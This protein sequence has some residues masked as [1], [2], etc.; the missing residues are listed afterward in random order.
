[1]TTDIIQCGLTPR[2]PVQLA[3][4]L[5]GLVLYMALCLSPGPQA[6]SPEGWQVASLAV[7]M[8]LWWVT[9]AAPIAVTALLPMIILPFAGV[10]GLSDV[11]ASYMS[12]IVI[13]LFAGFILARAIERWHLHE[14]I[15]LFVVDKM[16]TRPPT[17]IA[18]FMLSSALLSMWISNTATALMMTPIAL[19]V[20]QAASGDIA[21]QS[22]AVSPLMTALLLSVAYACSIGGLATPVGSPTNLIVIGYLADQDIAISFSQWM[23]IGVPVVVCL[24]PLAWLV[25]SWSARSGAISDTS[26]D[27]AVRTVI[28][29]ARQKLGP[30]TGPEKM[31]LVVF[32]AVAAAWILRTD[33]QRLPGFENLNDQIIAIVG[34][35]AMAVLPAFDR[36]TPSAPILDWANAERI[37]WG[38]VLLFGGG[39]SLAAAVKVSGLATYLA[40]FLTGLAGLPVFLVILGIALMILTVTEFTSNVATVS[41]MLPV[42]GAMAVA[43]GF[44]LYLLA[45]PTAMAASCAFMLPMATGPNAVAYA[46]GT[47][48]LGQMARIGLRVNLVAAIVIATVVTLLTA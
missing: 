21:G 11:G 45:A 30:M 29:A 26:D 7:L 4:L 47:L 22:K 2:T 39:L 42:L 32:A 44:D 16:G 20:A 34:V 27:G 46:S 19:S 25:L 15:A 24:L 28:R 35:V 18:G 14:R 31:T 23:G 17:L 8:I 5:G 12:P 41:A 36:K 43:T 9:E 40:G 1:M 3:G 37:P 10:M 6:L 13:L 38:V 33:M 48:S